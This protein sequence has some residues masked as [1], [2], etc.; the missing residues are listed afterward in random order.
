MSFSFDD[1]LSAGQILLL[2]CV[3]CVFLTGKAIWQNSFSKL[4]PGPWGMPVIAQITPEDSNAT[5]ASTED[6]ILLRSTKSLFTN[7]QKP[8]RTKPNN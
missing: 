3:V 8:L 4:P 7:L 2:C 5:Q 1:F 6:R